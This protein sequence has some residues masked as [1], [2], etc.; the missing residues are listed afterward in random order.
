M[1]KKIRLLVVDDS[2]F[3]RKVLITNLST[4]DDI[5]VVGYAANAYDAEKQVKLLKPDVM[6][7]DV[8]MPGMNGIDFLKKLLPEYP[9]PVILVSSVNMNTFDA[10]SAGAIDFVKKPAAGNT[11]SM[12]EFFRNLYSEIAAARQAKVRINR[13]P[14]SNQASSIASTSNRS[15][16]PHM[17]VSKLNS[18]IV[19][20][21]AS[22]GGTEAILSVLKQLPADCPPIVITQH[23]PEGFTKMYAERL[24]RIC[25]MEVR[26]AKNGDKVERG[27]ALIA[28]G[29]LQMKVVHGLKGYSVSCY[30]GEKVNG[31]RPSV[32]VLFNS[33]ADLIGRNS[34]GIILTG[35]GR[36]GA[37]G[38]L[39]MR[40]KGAYTIGQD[41]DSCV[42]YGMPM[43]AYQCGAVCTQAPLERI[44]SVLMNYLSH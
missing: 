12:N 26:E 25:A 7:L 19:A 27:L 23:M 16:L 18:I 8:E 38:L 20:I 2:I 14:S 44:P 28:P 10:L 29:G 24:N 11:D 17:L 13:S 5:E 4:H 34:V 35:M 39:K 22:T 37:D 42:V 9:I 30:P 33:V 41:H 21:G 6:T 32:D 43:A 3:F 1:F 15:A 40:S 31:L 36:D